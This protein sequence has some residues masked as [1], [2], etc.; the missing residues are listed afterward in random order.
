MPQPRVLIIGERHGVIASLMTMAGADVATCDLSETTTPHIPHFKGDGKWIRDL[1]WDLGKTSYFFAR[2]RRVHPSAHT[3][4][5]RLE[6][7][8]QWA[9][10]SRTYTSRRAACSTP[11]HAARA[12]PAAFL[13][14][15]GAMRCCSS[16]SQLLQHCFPLHHTTHQRAAQA[17]SPSRHHCFRPRFAARRFPMLLPALPSFLLCSTLTMLLSM[18]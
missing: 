9:A 16:R 12:L 5:H 14:C 2:W 15:Y 8:P 7:H 6:R 4:P 3:R 13:A 1:G 10:A 11:R 18:L 17:H